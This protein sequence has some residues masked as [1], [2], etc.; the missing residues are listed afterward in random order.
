M[1]RGTKVKVKAAR[2][3]FRAGDIGEFRFEHGGRLFIGGDFLGEI[4]FAIDE[5]EP[6]GTE[7]SDGRQCVVFTTVGFFKG[8]RERFV[9][10][11][12]RLESPASQLL[13]HP[14]AARMPRRGMFCRS[15]ECAKEAILRWPARSPRSAPPSPSTSGTT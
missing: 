7:L 2:G 10:H 9:L 4:D 8:G 1:E 12:E 14:D 6:A 11:A 3:P 5:V 13:E 15:V